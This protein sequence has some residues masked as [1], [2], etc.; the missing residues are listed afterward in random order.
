MPAAMTAPRA[1]TADPTL[2]HHHTRRCARQKSAAEMRWGMARGVARSGGAVGGCNV[3]PLGARQR[4]TREGSRRGAQQ[5]SRR[6]IAL[7]LHVAPLRPSYFAAP[8]AAMLSGRPLHRSAGSV[9]LPAESQVQ[10]PLCLLPLTTDSCLTPT[11]M[12]LPPPGPD[13]R[14]SSGRARIRRTR[15]SGP[16]GSTRWSRLRERPGPPPGSPRRSGR[17]RCGCRRRCPW[18]CPGRRCRGPERRSR[19]SRRWSSPR[20]PAS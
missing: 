17:S 7:Q 14:R 2:Q 6:D 10:I 11:G 16:P 18:P 12:A 1:A 4:R 3:L 20:R 9:P 15:S 13:P 19:R 5:G 8:P